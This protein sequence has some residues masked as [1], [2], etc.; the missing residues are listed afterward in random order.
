MIAFDLRKLTDALVKLEGAA[1]AL[2]ALTQQ[3]RQET[4]GHAILGARRNI[5]GTTPGAYQRTQ[6][7]LRG[8][9]TRG[10]TSRNSA[11]VMVFNTEPYARFVEYGQAPNDLT[12]A[13]DQAYSAVDP[14]LQVY[15]G[16]SGVNYSVAGPVIGPAQAFALYRLGQ[17]F[18]Q[19]VRAAI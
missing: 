8:L 11:S 3:V 10:Q 13:Q 7:Y 2:P 17:L 5:Y 16:R 15:L 19:K 1:D 6:D 14:A 12:A 18:A 9:N 4:L